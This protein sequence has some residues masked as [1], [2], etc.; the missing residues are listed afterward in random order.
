MRKQDQQCD[1][2]LRAL[3]LVQNGTLKSKVHGAN[4]PELLERV[5]EWV[6]PLPGLDDLEVIAAVPYKSGTLEA[7]PRGIMH[8]IRDKRCWS[9]CCIQA[10]YCC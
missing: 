8:S 6:T 5:A 1:R 2:D 7:G 10:A 9:C 3:F 4:I